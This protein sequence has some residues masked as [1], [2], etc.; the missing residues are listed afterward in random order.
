MKKIFAIL[1]LCALILAGCSTNE[2]E[3]LFD[4]ATEG[5]VSVILQDT[6]DG[7]IHYDTIASDGRRQPAQPFESEAI[8]ILT[9][10]DDCFEC[11]TDNGQLTNRLLRTELLDADGQPA[12]ITEVESRIF[13][14][15]AEQQHVIMEMRILRAGE[16]HFVTLDL[17]VNLWS[18]HVVLYYDPAA[19]QLVELYTYDA[20]RVIGLKILNL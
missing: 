7:T 5:V 17:N 2:N 14:L 18:P 11:N 10:A 16:R 20:T 15:V 3:I 8:E 6:N 12:E 4:E 1:L 9:A 19:D 13:E